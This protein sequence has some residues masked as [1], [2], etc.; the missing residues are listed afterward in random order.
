MYTQRC[1]EQDIVENHHAM[2]RELV[3][4]RKKKEKEKQVTLDG[5]F[6]KVPGPRAFSREGILKVVAEF[7]VCDDQV[8]LMT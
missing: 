7:I 1:A 3:A 2:P 8:G 5:V 6:A 4:E